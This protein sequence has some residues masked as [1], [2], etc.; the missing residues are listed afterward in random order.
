MRLPTLSALCLWLGCSAPPPVEDA[1]SSAAC[2][3][4]GRVTAWTPA[5]AL[6]AASGAKLTV[7]G[8]EPATPARGNN[9][10]QVLLEDGSGAPLSAAAVA[11][12]AFMPDHGHASPSQVSVTPGAT[13]G[14]YA[15][16]PLYF[17]M[18]GV[19]RVT[20]TA[21]AERFVLFLCIP[22]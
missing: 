16:S 20:V 8:A 7:L 21:G 5:L 18:P 10:W 22:G 12:E 15:L 14:S 17:F 13:A 1:G 6:T 9:R 11:V 19:W 2:E 3:R 4:D